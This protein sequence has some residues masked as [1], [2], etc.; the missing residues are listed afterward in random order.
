MKLYA[1][2]FICSLPQWSVSQTA[3]LES[4]TRS[5]YVCDDTPDLNK[6]ILEYV[7]SQMNKKVGRGECWDLAAGALNSN[8]AN[9]DKEFKYGRE[10]S[11]KKEC[12]YPG[13]IM[14]FENVEIEYTKGKSNY[15][16]KMAR[17]TAIIYEVK[18]EGE[19]TLA[20]QNTT[21]HGRKVG[22]SSLKLKDITKGKYKFFRPEKK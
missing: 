3:S 22:L 16:E 13:D 8:N 14:Q 2:F 9:W 4:N 21:Q 6:K 18:G 19:F 12:V 17:H 15:K 10:V 5:Y 20:D 7:N 11:L 1:L